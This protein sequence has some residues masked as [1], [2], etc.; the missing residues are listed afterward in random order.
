MRYRRQRASIAPGISTRIRD[1][2][3]AAAS[4]SQ[5]SQ[6]LLMNTANLRARNPLRSVATTQWTGEPD[7]DRPQIVMV[8][9][10]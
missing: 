6:P 8:H 2:R 3:V 4:T 1:G 7:H 10:Y 5:V 9:V